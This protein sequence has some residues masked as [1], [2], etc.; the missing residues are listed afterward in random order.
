MPNGA[1]LESSHT[2][3]LHV[4]TIPAAARDGHIL[5]GLASHSLLSIAKFCDHGC[6][7]RFSKDYCRI[8]LDDRLLLEGPRDPQTNLWLLPLCPNPSPLHPQDAPAHVSYHAH[9]T[10]SKSELLQYLHACAYSP[11]PSTWKKAIDNNQYVTWPGLT[12]KA[13]T[14]HL[15]KSMATA[16]E[17]LASRRTSNTRS[18]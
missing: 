8:Y 7:V 17:H 2:C 13:V 14:H 4:P 18:R 6:D 5:P 3:Q 1:G 12:T 9:Q 11:V 16:Q 10:S 15:P